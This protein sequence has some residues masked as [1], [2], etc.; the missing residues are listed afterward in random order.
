M[1]NA[2]CVSYVLYTG[3]CLGIL[4]GVVILLIGR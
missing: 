3:A 2:E 4:I 1:C